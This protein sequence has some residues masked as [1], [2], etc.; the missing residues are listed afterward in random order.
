MN[1]KEYETMRKNLL[2]EAQSLI[3]AGKPDEATAK[4]EEIETLDGK[5]D[6][7][8]AAQANA[9]ALE[10]AA[11][12]QNISNPGITPVANEVIDQTE[13]GKGSL[14]NQELYKSEE[15]KTAWTKSMMGQKLTSAEAETYRLANEYTHTT[16]NTGAVIP[17]SVADR[18]WSEVEDMYP[19]FADITKTYVKGTLK[20]VQSDT[21]SDAAWYDEATATE[22]GKEIFKTYQLT[23][24]ELSRAITVSWKLRDMAMNDFLNYIQRRLAERMGKALGY[25]VTNGKGKP[26]TDDTFKEEPLGVVTALLADGAQVVNYTEGAMAYNDIIAARAKIKSGYANG[27]AIYANANTIW[28]GLANVKDDNG[29]P[30]FVADPSAGGVYKVLGL[31]VKEDASMSDGDVLISNAAAGYQANINKQVEVTKEEHVKARETDYC[32]YAIADGA[33]LTVNAHALLTSVSTI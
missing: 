25:G 19:Y 10:G 26:G 3:D 30:I 29:R 33:P 31:T 17:E 16:E 8:C 18:I 21:S 2:D 23:G 4:M 27:L 32:A 11:R 15:Y 20:L 24:C 28:T 5:W 9:R 22:D 13:T 12:K 6:A 14:V 1:F 7:I